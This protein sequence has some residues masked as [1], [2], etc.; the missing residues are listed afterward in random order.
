MSDWNVV[1]TVRE[2]GYGP[3]RAFFERFGQVEETHYYNVLTL[4]AAAPR[5]VLAEAQAQ[6][7]QDAALRAALARVMPV[8]AAFVFQ[9]PEEFT[10]RAEELI[11]PWVPRFEGMRFHVRMHRRGFKGKLTS[12]VE[13]R[14]LDHYLLDRLAARGAS[15]R[16]D[17]ADPDLILAVETVDSRA[18]LSL[19]TR[20][21]RLRYPLLHL[22]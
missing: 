21:E 14:F 9:S 7:E 16:V 3:A 20:P 17:F 5:E 13:E 2:K 19:W 11:A 12:P 6:V 10:H 4:T 22:D 8:E 1:I 15:A 18:G